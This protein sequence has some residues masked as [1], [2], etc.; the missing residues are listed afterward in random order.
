MR[1]GKKHKNAVRKAIDPSRR[2]Q[3]LDEMNA[4]Y[5]RLHADPDAWAQEAAERAAWE[6]TVGD[7]VT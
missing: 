3:L 2:N 6:D 4:A 7:G 5:E 1:T